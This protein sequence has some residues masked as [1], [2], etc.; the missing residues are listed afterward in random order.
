MASPSRRSPR[1]LIAEL[2]S[3]AHQFGFFQAVRLLGLATRSPDRRHGPLPAQLR[4]RTPATLC[5]PPSELVSYCEPERHAPAQDTEALQLDELVV[6]FMG[7]T[8]PSGVLPTAYTELIIERKQ[9]QHDSAPHAF[10]DLFSHR[11]IALFYGAWRKYRYWI[12][13]E[14]GEADGFSRNLLDFSGMTA[15]SGESRSVTDPDCPDRPSDPVPA[16]YRPFR[17]RCREKGKR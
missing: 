8:G 3:Q 15:N 14:A 5:Y 11:A 6:S 16:G 7:L 17:I 1:D 4:F 10:F 2:K 13:V 12:E 9:R